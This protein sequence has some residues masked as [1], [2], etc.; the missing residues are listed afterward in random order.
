MLIDVFAARTASFSWHT[1]RDLPPARLR[2][3]TVAMFQGRRGQAGSS[4]EEL[5]LLK[6]NVTVLVVI[7]LKK[8][9]FFR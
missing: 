5:L 2:L 8:G 3:G 7:I 1:T 6:R 4:F 9:G